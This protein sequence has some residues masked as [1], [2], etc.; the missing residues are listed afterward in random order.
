MC[1]IW[2]FFFGAELA[3][4]FGEGDT[5]VSVRSIFL[6][7]M[8]QKVLVPL[9]R[10]PVLVGP[11]PTPWHRRPSSFMYAA[12]QVGPSLGGRHSWWCWRY[13]PVDGSSTDTEHLV[14]KA[15]GYW[16][17]AAAMGERV[18]ERV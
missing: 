17:M 13:W 7:W 8:M 1:A 14:R 2:V 9:V 6:K 18:C 5:L 12:S 4:Y 3:D 11:L 15:E 10:C 16:R